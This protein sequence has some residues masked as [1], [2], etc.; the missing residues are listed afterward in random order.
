M[1]IYPVGVSGD[2]KDGGVGRVTLDGA[3]PKLQS[4]VVKALSAGPD[5]EIHG[6]VRHEELH[7]K[8]EINII[9]I[10]MLT[11]SLSFNMKMVVM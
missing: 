5:Q 6:A 9:D 1:V 4:R 8:I 11:L 7:T 3:K 10:G 2:D